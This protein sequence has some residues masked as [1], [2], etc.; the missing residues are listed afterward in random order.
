MRKIEADYFLAG[1]LVVSGAVSILLGVN[2]QMQA[3]QV[4]ERISITTPSGKA[5]EQCS[6]YDA[7]PNYDTA[8]TLFVAGGSAIASA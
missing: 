5:V 2:N 1:A 4:C 8:M 6:N 3:D 7:Y